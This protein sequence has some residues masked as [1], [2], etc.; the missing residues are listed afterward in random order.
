MKKLRKIFGASRNKIELLLAFNSIEE[1]R[2]V[3]SVLGGNLRE[4][5]H[6]VDQRTH[7]ILVF[8]EDV[9][10]LDRRLQ[11]IKKNT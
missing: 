6:L 4:R 3:C 8:V 9:N 11:A 10:V 1:R 2:D 7:Q 5:N